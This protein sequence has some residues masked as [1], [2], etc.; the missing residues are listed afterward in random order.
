VLADGRETRIRGRTWLVL[1]VLVVWANTHGSVLVGAALTAG[2][3]G[4]G[5][6]RA[7]VLHQGRATLAY[8]G[9]AITSAASVVCTPYGVGVLRYYASVSRVTPVL[10]RNITE[11]GPSDPLHRDSAAFFVVAVVTLAAVRVGWRRGARPDPLL[12]VAAVALF[13]LA[14][15]AV[16][17]QVWF[18]FAA[19]LLAADALA[20]GTRKD[21]A[22][23]RA[24][25]AATAGALA[26]AGLA[27]LVLLAA[28]PDSQF[29]S[30]VPLASVSQ[31]TA[32]AVR[33]PRADVLA[34][35]WSASAMLWLH[36]SM[37]GRVGFDARL[38]QYTVAQISAYAAFLAGAGHWQR[39][40]RPYSIVVVSTA[41]HP[42][43]AHA[44]TRLPGWHV[45]AASRSGM[46]VERDPTTTPRRSAG[47]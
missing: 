21:P 45:A 27:G 22:L 9:L 28:T 43:L 44:L 24:F 4:Y 41:L 38:E 26:A 19:S 18:G 8:L 5:L 13:G 37:V 23:G 39:V 3:A 2:Y 32:L 29:E 33:Q 42:R 46:V 14:L 16:R 35:D 36:P 1:P 7:M 34:D 20:R 11:W 15:T 31:A 30:L 47:W 6:V 40:M 17:D 25:S 12:A 10:A